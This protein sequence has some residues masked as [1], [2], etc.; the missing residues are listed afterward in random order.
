MFGFA[1]AWAQSP[2]PPVASV[3]E[4]PGRPERS[5]GEVDPTVMPATS[6]SAP[7][8]RV[9]VYFSDQ[10]PEVAALKAEVARL[11][12]LLEQQTLTPSLAEILRVPEADLVHRL[13]RS[14][15]MPTAAVL[16]DCLRAA[17][18]DNVWAA[19]RAE[20][21]FRLALAKFKAEHP[22][23]DDP[24]G[25]H[26][27]VWTP[28]YTVAADQLC[29]RLYELAMPSPVVESFRVKLNEGI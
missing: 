12:K 24:F 26:A 16:A 7:A 20:G 1:W 2:L 4:M 10:Q 5:T 28:F 19:L 18:H 14:E 13:D 8:A 23:G 27:N 3:L 11:R 29:R 22:R 25:W 9:P 15:L 21:D 6:V 17:G